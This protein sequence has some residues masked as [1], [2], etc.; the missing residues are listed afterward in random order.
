ME[1]SDK[2]VLITQ[3]SANSAAEKA[4]LRVG[5][6]IQKVDGESVTR[7]VD[8]TARIRNKAIGDLIRLEVNRE[9]AIQNI[10]V[11]LGPKPAS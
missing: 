11:T 6:I 5:D 9:G 2:G 3:I 7:P 4:N 8:V 10:N 1:S